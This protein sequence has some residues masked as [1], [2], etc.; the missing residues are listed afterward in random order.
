MEEDNKPVLITTKSLKPEFD[1]LKKIPI[2]CDNVSTQTNQLSSKV[3]QFKNANL[4]LFC[5][6]SISVNLLLFYSLH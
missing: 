4:F 2:T 1:K 6:F 5:Y 3:F